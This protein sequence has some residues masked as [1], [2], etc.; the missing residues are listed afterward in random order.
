MMFAQ[1]YTP[2]AN[3][4]NKDLDLFLFKGWFRSGQSINT[5]TIL[6]FE[7]KLFSPVRVRLPLKD[8]QFKKR[9]KKIWNRNSNFKTICRPVILN[10]EKEKLYKH[11][12]GKYKNAVPSTLKQYLLDGNDKSIYNTYETCIYNNDELIAGSFFDLGEKCMASILGIFNTDYEKY[13]LGIYT[14]LAEIQFGIDNGFDFYFPGY[15]TP[16][17][18]KFDYKLRIG[19]LEY[20]EPIKDSWQPYEQMKES[21]LPSNLIENKLKQ[22]STI[23]NE[24]Q[25]EHELYYYP[26][27][28]KG[29]KIQNK[30]VIELD[31]PLFIH[32]LTETNNLALSYNYEFGSFELSRYLGFEFSIIDYPIYFSHETYPTF[33]NTLLKTNVVIKNNDPNIVVKKIKTMAKIGV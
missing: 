1:Y 28:N 25:I 20:Y 21:E 16:G 3:L 12:E 7:D 2:S 30:D 5:S 6:N 24:A 19:T 9:L 4:H 8:Y 22:L 23:L 27:L 33:S 32:L 10:E 14:M 15:V 18:P 31:S 13:S 29:F 11:F 17:Y 26:F